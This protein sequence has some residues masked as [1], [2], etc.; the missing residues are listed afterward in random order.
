MMQQSPAPA[1]NESNITFSEHSLFNAV[2]EVHHMENRQYRHEQQSD[3][4]NITAS[5][6]NEVIKARIFL[7]INNL[8]RQLLAIDAIKYYYQS[9]ANVTELIKDYFLEILK[10]E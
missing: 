2:S 7:E 9:N 10:Y 1:F 3:I 8:D 5:S 6:P 4:F